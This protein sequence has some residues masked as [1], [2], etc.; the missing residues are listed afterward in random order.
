MS[1][2]LIFLL[3]LGFTSVP[4]E[5]TAES[6]FVGCVNRPPD[7]TLQLGTI[8]S[9]ELFLLSGEKDVMEEH[10]GEMIRVTGDVTPGANKNAHPTLAA[11]KIQT[12]AESCTSA[13]PTT[14]AES[15]SGKVGEDLVAVPVT[16]TLTEDQTTPG[17]QTQAAA[18]PRTREEQPAAPDHPDQVAQSEAAADVNASAVDRTEILPGHALGVNASGDA[19]AASAAESNPTDAIPASSA[20]NTAVVG[21]P[22][23]EVP[24]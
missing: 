5:H 1:S 20:S 16:T 14:R 24:R 11:A 21:S 10:V 13:S 3:L 2:V 17:F 12:V 22:G 7:G 6:T 19:T 23:N 4:A 8:Q 15:V 18:A 9:G